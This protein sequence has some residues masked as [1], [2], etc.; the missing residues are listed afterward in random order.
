MPIFKNLENPRR[1]VMDIDQMIERFEQHWIGPAFISYLAQNDIYEEYVLQSKMGYIDY[2]S[3]W[4]KEFCI[5]TGC[6]SRLVL[7]YLAIKDV[8]IYVDSHRNPNP[9]QHAQ[10]KRK[11][12]NL[13][14]KIEKEKQKCRGLTFKHIMPDFRGDLLL[15]DYDLI[16]DETDLLIVE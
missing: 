13:D 3:R 2:F 15:E 4:F 10:L 14:Q 9:W 16:F 1:E 12:H 7:K 8:L 5:D 11:I 6:P